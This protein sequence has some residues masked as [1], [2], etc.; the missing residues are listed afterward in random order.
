MNPHSLPD[1]LPRDGFVRLPM[2]LKFLPVGRTTWLNG[3]RDGRYPKA[4]KV[5]RCSLWRVADIRL[6]ISELEGSYPSE[7]E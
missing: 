2:V 3:V 4:V 5:G 6:V 7:D 1:A